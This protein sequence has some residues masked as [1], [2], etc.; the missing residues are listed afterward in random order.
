MLELL[1]RAPTQLLF[2]KCWDVQRWWGR[3]MAV[4][5]GHEV[6]AQAYKGS[7]SS[8]LRFKKN[9]MGIVVSSSL[10]TTDLKGT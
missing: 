8:C 4:L 3:V 2:T 10:V 7:N 1:A 5:V 9:K 6:R